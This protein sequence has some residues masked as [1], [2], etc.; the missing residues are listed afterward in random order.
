[1]SFKNG[2][3]KIK[4]SR[5]PFCAAGDAMK[6]DNIR[7]GMN[8]VPFNKEL[9]RLMLTVKKGKARQY[10]ITWGDE[11]KTFSAEQLGR[12][13]NLADEFQTNP[14]SEAFAKVDEAVAKKQAFETK[15]IKQTFRSPEAKADMDGVAAQ[16]E[17]ER[18][19]LVAAIKAAFVPVSHTIKI[20][21]K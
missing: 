8:L 19:E 20:S 21:A 17:K 1:M 13:I 16:T 7:S 6:D 5:Y 3:L 10:K 2:E 9:N 12:G 4:S 14:F 11:T 15:Q 18:E